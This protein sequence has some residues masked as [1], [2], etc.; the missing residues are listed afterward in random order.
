MAASGK[1]TKRQDGL[2]EGEFNTHAGRKQTY[3]YRPFTEEE[4]ELLCQEY[5]TKGVLLWE[6]HF[7]DVLPLNN[8]RYRVNKMG[9]RINQESKRVRPCTRFG[10]LN[11]PENIKFVTE[12]YGAMSATQL[13]K[14]L[15]CSGDMIFKLIH[16]N[17]IHVNE[18]AQIERENRNALARAGKI[19]AALNGKS[20]SPQSLC[21]NCDNMSPLRC[22]K[23]RTGK[24]EWTEGILVP[25]GT[26]EWN[27]AVTE[28]PTYKPYPV[29]N[30][31]GV[32]L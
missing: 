10:E 14:I 30:N 20:V 13:S 3:R 6:E 19:A 18:K 28:C 22:K 27:V 32:E 12:N 26:G 21:S 7:Q 24:G 5:P 2:F 1:K 23:V 29:R 11:T 4:K 17:D 31:K 8:W 25:W 15:K 9:L 16:V